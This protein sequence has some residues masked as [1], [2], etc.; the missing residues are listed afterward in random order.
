M[1]PIR[2]ADVPLYVQVKNHIRERI[3]SGELR[4]H[5][6]LPGE[7][8]LVAQLGLSRTTVRQA[9]NDLVAE[10][11]LY[12]H[13]GKGTF[14]APRK[15]GQNLTSLTGFAEELRSMGL[16]PQIEV[17]AQEFRPA[18]RGVALALRCEPGENVAFIARRILTEGEPL[19]VDRT[20]LIRSVGELVLQADLVHESIYRRIERVGFPIQEGLQTIG[21]IGMSPNDADL[22]D[23][24]PGSPALFLQRVTFV[25]EESPIEYSEAVYRSERF[26]YQTQLKRAAVVW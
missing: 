13:H 25:D 7:R 2:G 24:E 1:L 3:E 21:A 6:A 14:V 9:L 16:A 26:Q 23:V 5:D 10:G 18:P 4:A 19:L 11:V 20:Y 8:E 15:Y 17:L 22:L 12:R